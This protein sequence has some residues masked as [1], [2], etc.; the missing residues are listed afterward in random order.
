MEKNKTE[1][2]SHKFSD[3]NTP[4]VITMA[5]MTHHIIRFVLSSVFVFK[6]AKTTF[7]FL[8]NSVHVFDVFASVH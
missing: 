8:C 7:H 6:H 3:M 2:S 5:V 4:D 1:A